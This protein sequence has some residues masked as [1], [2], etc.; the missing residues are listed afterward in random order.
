MKELLYLCTNDGSDMRVNKELKTLSKTHK[1]TYLGV[2]NRNSES[3]CSEFCTE[4]NLVDI[5]VKSISGIFKYWR[6]L[7]NILKSKKF[8]TYHVV[9]EQ[10][11]LIIW[12]FL[13]NKNVVL[14][15]FDSIFLKL[16]K[17]KNKF[18][19]VKKLLYSM[20]AKIIVTD[21]FRKSLLPSFVMD[22]AVVIP[23][24]P[25]SQ[26]K[27]HSF[28]TNNTNNIMICFFGSLT[29]ERGGKIVADLLAANENIQCTCAGWIADSYVNWLITQPRVDYIGVISQDEANKYLSTNADYIVCVYPTNN[30]NNIYA[31]PNKIYDSIHTH[32]PVIINEEILVSQFVKEKNL[33]VI[34]PANYSATELSRELLQ[35]KNSFS[36]SQKLQN[37]YCWENYE[38][39][40]QL[41]H[42]VK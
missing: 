21:D 23:N 39:T 22:K 15:I 19:F 28:N 9:E 36:F 17:P 1:V 25:F 8:D 35:K 2:G 40:L 37:E 16:N 27:Q 30:L 20:A 32:T 11:L 31:S 38:R 6:T 12:P 24:V 29:K 33:G 26:P 41:L 10:L 4:F 7:F 34:I 3:F 42:F 14:D 18:Y 13:F 5:N